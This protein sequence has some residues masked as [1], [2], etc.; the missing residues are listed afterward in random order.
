L[1]D[2]KIIDCSYFFYGELLAA[3]LERKSFFALGKAQ[4]KDWE[5]KTD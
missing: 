3:R 5:R 4:A 1:K 2:L